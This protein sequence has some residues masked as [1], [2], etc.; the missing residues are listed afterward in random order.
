MNDFF[1][2]EPQED[3]NIPMYT[4]GAAAMKLIE[5]NLFPKWGLFVYKDL[6][7]SADGPP[8]ELLA[9]IHENA[10]ILAPRVKE[11][12]VKGMLICEDRS[13]NKT[14]EMKSPCGQLITVKVP[15]FNGRYAA[16][17]DIELEIVK[18]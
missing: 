11:D 15:S 17:E 10:I 3:Q 2:Y 8:P 9:F 18:D 12:L 16:V 4:Y 7:Q 5:G 1:L 6:K 14:I 13:F